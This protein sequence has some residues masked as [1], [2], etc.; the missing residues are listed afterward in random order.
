[1]PIPKYFIHERMKA[2]KEREKMLGQILA[3]LGPKNKDDAVDEVK[4]S[5]E[6]AV[7]MI[8]I[9]ER[10]RQGILIIHIIHLLLLSRLFTNVIA[11]T[12]TTSYSESSINNSY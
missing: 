7:R 10:A 12:Y 8:Q 2:L 6:D 9:H 11:I 3:K 1:M 4:M 5:L